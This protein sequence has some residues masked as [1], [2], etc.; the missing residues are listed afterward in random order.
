MSNELPMAIAPDGQVIQLVRVS[1]N[2]ADVC[3]SCYMQKECTDVTKV[4]LSTTLGAK[5]S[6]YDSYDRLAYWEKVSEL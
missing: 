5:C 4:T 6:D 3:S 1:D 2:A